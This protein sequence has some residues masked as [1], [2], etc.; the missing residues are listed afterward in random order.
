M[1][2][3]KNV[4]EDALVA[5]GRRC[6]IC[7]EFKGVKIEVHHIIPKEQGGVDDFHNAIPLCFDCHADAGHY[8]S[9]HP[10]GSKYSPSEL[11][12]HRDEWYRKVREGG[13]TL[14]Q[15]TYNNL[16]CQYIVTSNVQAAND[17]INN[18]IKIGYFR[19]V[20]YYQPEL[21]IEEVDYFLSGKIKEICK[22]QYFESEKEYLS[23]YPHA[24]KKEDGASNYLYE[25]AF[26][27]E[28]I[29][30]YNNLVYSIL[31]EK[32]Y[33]LNE[34]AQR[35]CYFQGCGGQY[36]ETVNVPELNMCFL[37]MYNA[38]EGFIHL[39][40]IECKCT[41]GNLIN[42]IKLPKVMIHSKATVLIPISVFAEPIDSVVYETLNQEHEKLSDYEV[43]EFNRVR[44]RNLN[45]SK[46]EMPTIGNSII[47]Q[48][49][50]YTF[51]NR[52][53]FNEIHPLELNCMYKLDRH[54]CV[55][56]CPHVF[57]QDLQQNVCY[58][59][60]LFCNNYGI[61]YID[62]IKIPFNSIRVIISE[63]E[64][65]TTF[66]KSIYMNDQK[67]M[68]NEIVLNK[69]EYVEFDVVGGST[70]FVEGYYL[71]I[72]DPRNNRIESDKNKLIKN[73][74]YHY[75]S[76]NNLKLTAYS[77]RELR[78]DSLRERCKATNA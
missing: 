61:S 57:V 41:N 60:E 26:Q 54:L 59:G 16:V 23:M 39:D 34:I 46:K 42:I 19:D 44:A 66:I 71:S 56:S 2:F 4:K 3:P 21:L 10:K 43:Q 45:A 29:K 27:L 33:E 75:K 53:Y 62:S 52:D 20:L 36:V 55:G 72:A 9:R 63:L 64:Y 38:T 74:S 32:G 28:E 48:S 18:R 13:T 35:N 6:C 8:H 25:R 15:Y 49:I 24:I 58:L 22:S 68:N 17:I 51:G 78:Y 1:S 5:S 31:L 7:N 77:Q 40:E 65:E 76:H 69:N 73:F 37:S 11:R 12:K 30:S 47:P 14:Y 50:K 67:I 70:I